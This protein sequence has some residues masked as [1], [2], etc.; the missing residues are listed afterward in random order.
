MERSGRAFDD[1]I[2]VIDSDA[3]PNDECHWLAW[4]TEKPSTDCPA[5]NDKIRGSDEITN[6]GERLGHFD[7]LALRARSRRSSLCGSRPEREVGYGQNAPK[8][9]SRSCQ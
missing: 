2:G 4:L 1:R 8:P 5:R 6:Q 9:S 7:S 3:D